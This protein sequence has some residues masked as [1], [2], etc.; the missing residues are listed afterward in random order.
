MIALN[1]MSVKSF[2]SAGPW[3]LW[4]VSPSLML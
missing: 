2:V 4:C 3:G 1:I